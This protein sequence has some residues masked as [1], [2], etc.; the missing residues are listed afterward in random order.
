MAIKEDYT[1]DVIDARNDIYE[2]GREVD[3]VQFAPA[4]PVNGRDET[5]DRKVNLSAVFVRP[6]LFTGAALGYGVEK[7]ELFA[8]VDMVCMVADDGVNK[9]DEFDVVI[10]S[11]GTAY[12]IG[13]A[14][15]LQPG[16]VRILWFVGMTK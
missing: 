1:Q 12:K 15:C 6:E 13:I 9:L 7:P 16:P 5:L 3:F 11:D 14:T 2:A 4:D 10:D 8:N